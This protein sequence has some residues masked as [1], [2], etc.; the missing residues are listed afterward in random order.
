MEIFFQYFDINQSLA[1]QT[2]QPI[3]FC[4]QKLSSAIQKKGAIVDKVDT[5]SLDF[6]VPFIRAL[7]RGAFFQG[8]YRG[9]VVFTSN[10]DSLILNYRISILPI[11]ISAISFI[12]FGFVTSIFLPAA[13]DDVEFPMNFLLFISGLVMAAI[14]YFAGMFI[15]VWRIEKFLLSSLKTSA[16]Y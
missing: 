2:L 14:A 12:L 7:S 15:V 10:P 16:E 3:P 11:R 1:L 13:S 8:V 4:I 5:N 6:S 9:T